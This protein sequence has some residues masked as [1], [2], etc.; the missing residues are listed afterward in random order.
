M[1]KWAENQQVKKRSPL[2]TLMKKM[3]TE[4]QDH[5]QAWPFLEPVSGVP[6]YYD[7]I[8]EPMGIVL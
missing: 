6:D 8:K 5:Q 2:Y 7:V 3:V 4:L 1:S